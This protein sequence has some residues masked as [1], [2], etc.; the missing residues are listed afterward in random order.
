MKMKNAKLGGLKAHI[1]HLFPKPSNSYQIIYE[2]VCG[3]GCGMRM[4][5]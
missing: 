2:F 1:G 3:V 4:G 5:V